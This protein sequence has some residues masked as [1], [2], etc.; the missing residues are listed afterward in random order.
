MTSTGQ[1]RG[2]S[3]WAILQ[4]AFAPENDGRSAGASLSC[5]PDIGQTI[6]GKEGN[7]RPESNALGRVM[8]ANPGFQSASLLWGH[9]ERIN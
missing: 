4:E 8:G 6:S 7:L 9:G 3:F 5:D 1:N 2:D